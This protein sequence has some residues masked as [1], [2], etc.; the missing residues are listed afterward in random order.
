MLKVVSNSTPLIHLGKIGLLDLL[1]HQYEQIFIPTAVWKEV[2]E[3]GNDEPDAKA[4]AE[5]NWIK[6]REVKNSPLLM[7][8]LAQLDQ[9]E[10]EAIVLAIEIGAD[11][12]LLDESEARRI[13]D[14]YGLRKTG[15]LGVLIKAKQEGKIQSIKFFLDKLRITGF[16]LS[17][18][19]YN[20][21]LKIVDE[22]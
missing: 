18:R 9:G 10:A 8:L 17:K 4:V 14:L 5:A 2:V 19:V 21:I 13:A 6:V 16:Y 22:N 15:S 1:K 12:I 7:I 3:E 20:E 11:L